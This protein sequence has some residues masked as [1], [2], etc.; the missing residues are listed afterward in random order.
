MKILLP[1]DGSAL[2]LHALDFALRL[3]KDG[4]QADFVLANVQAPAS[5]YEMVVLPDPQAL[6]ALRHAAG[7]DLLGAAQSLL[8][9][10]G[11]SFESVV[12]SGE[13]AQALLDLVSEYGCDLVVMASH[14]S[15]ALRGA[16][17]GSVS[18]A[19]HHAAPVPVLLVKPQQD[20]LEPQDRAEAEAET[21]L[22]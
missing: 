16:W 1:M 22:D 18:Q 9:A 12:V 11:Q 20:E 21:A 10:A 6:D 15:G 3:V 7:A 19:L 8:E 17:Q 4:L 5:L 14:G 2:S 13:P